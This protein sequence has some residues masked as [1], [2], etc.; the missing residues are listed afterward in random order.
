[1]AAGGSTDVE[2]P[3]SVV[4]AGSLSIIINP[5]S[6]GSDEVTLLN[7]TAVAVAYSRGDMNCN[8]AIGVDDVTLFVEALLDPG[9]FDA[10]H[11]NCGSIQVD[12]NQ[13]GVADGA[14]IQQFVNVLLGN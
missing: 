9:A 2:I 10:A 13:S 3:L 5:D 7:N 6:N 12:I 1:M 4:P 11:P 14:D 8:G